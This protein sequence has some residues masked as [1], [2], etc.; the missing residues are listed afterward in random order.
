MADVMQ[1]RRMIA[2]NAP[3]PAH[4][5]GASIDIVAA[6]PKIEELVL[7]LHPQQAGSGTPSGSNKRGLSGW[8][9]PTLNIDG[10]PVTFP[11]TLNGM[12]AGTYDLKTG[13]K[14]SEYTS[15]GLA[16]SSVTSYSKSGSSS[17]FWGYFSTIQIYNA[18]YKPLLCNMF[19]FVEYSYNYAGVPDWSMCGASAY[20]NSMWFKV[21]TSVL[22]AASLDG[23]K[24]WLASNPIQ[25]VGPRSSGSRTE[26]VAE[27]LPEITRGQHHIELIPD[28]S[29][30]SYAEISYWT[31]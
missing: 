21:P 5:T 26:Y 4:R 11:A 28:Y 3:H 16:A 23:A 2:L 20:P 22:P 18:V 8:Y 31:H 15:A 1:L 12:Y 30:D 29:T 9:F 14:T 19:S 17:I 13:Y 6:E 24:Q 27:A 10:T 25:M 7:H